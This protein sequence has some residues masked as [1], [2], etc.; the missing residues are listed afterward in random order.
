M[1]MRKTLQSVKS[2]NLNGHT[3]PKIFSDILNVAK[4]PVHLHGA[5]L[6]RIRPIERS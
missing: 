1:D 5:F 4:S 2:R 6:C 3:D